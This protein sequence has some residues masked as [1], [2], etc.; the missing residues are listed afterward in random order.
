MKTFTEY[1]QL[2]P[3]AYYLGSEDGDGCMSE[4]LADLI[5]EAIEPAR[6]REAEGNYSYFDLT[7]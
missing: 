3:A 2:P 7:N 5:A 1:N 4:T 6:L